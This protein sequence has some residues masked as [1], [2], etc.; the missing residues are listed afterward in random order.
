[1]KVLHPIHI[2]PLSIQ[3]ID[4]LET[5]EELIH[6]CFWGAENYR[7]FLGQPEYFSQKAVIILAPGMTKMVGFFMAR[8]VLEN[9]ELLKIGIY[10]EYQN[11]GIGTKLLNA[12]FAEGMRR[13]C[14]RCF[15][16]VRKSNEQAIQFYYRHQF[17]LAGE[18]SN[19]YTE[20]LEDALVMERWL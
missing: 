12:A 17:K 6:L 15:L 9:L 3:D 14:L 1:M 2:D 18:R 7:R 5:L 16:E 20:P 19:Y 13:G 8:G 4:E 11:L 10:P